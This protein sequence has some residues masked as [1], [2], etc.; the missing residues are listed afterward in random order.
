MN[1]PRPATEALKRSA[2]RLLLPASKATV[3]SK[4]SGSQSLKFDM[5]ALFRTAVALQ[6][7]Q[8]SSLSFPEIA[9]SLDD[10]PTSTWDASQA[11]T[12]TSSSSDTTTS[13]FEDTFKQSKK[14]CRD[15]HDHHHQ[16]KS[17]RMVRSKALF[18]E[19]SLL[20]PQH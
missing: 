10:D 18:S 8:D 5:T 15:L 17:F 14:R 2:P 9:W 12:T 3:S 13:T 19:L 11:T 16:Q 1:T 4:S 7:E 6:D 20:S